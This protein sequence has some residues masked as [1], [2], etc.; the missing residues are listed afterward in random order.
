[1]PLGDVVSRARTREILAATRL[2]HVRYA[3]R[4]VAVLAEEVAREGHEILPLNIGDPLQFDF[5][6]PL[7]LIEAV[8]RAMHEGRSG[9]APSTGV[10]QALEAIRREAHRKG[11]RNVQSVFVT[12]GVS[13]AVDLCLGAL[14]NPGENVLTPCP[15]YPLYWAVLARLGA[16]LNT[17]AL[18]ESSAWEPD[19]DDMARRI[20]PRTRAVVVINPNNPTGT[21][22]SRAV[23]EGI[24]ELARQHN[25]VI[26]AD[27]IYDKLTL[28]GEHVSLAALAPDVP[29]ITFGGLSKAYL[30]PGWRIGWGIASGDGAALQPYLEGIHKLLRSR[31]SANHPEQYAI[32]PAL[33]GPQDHLPATLNKLRMRRDLTVEFAN[34]TP[35]LSC[36]PPQGAFYA[37]PRLEIPDG[38]EEFVRAL[39]REK[40]VLL[41]HGSGFGQ[42]PG[43]RHLRIVFLPDE[44]TLQRA[45]GAIA[46]FLRERYG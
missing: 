15:E 18:D 44:S 8:A 25:L 39:L 24:A 40:H 42:A 5:H 19:L 38:D 27:E 43:T 9:Y 20:T 29:V 17:Y 1:M 28:E 2:E 22:Y 30:A 16:E 35:R 36:V 10:P 26:F 41:V 31:L 14:V 4:D 32:G 11:I 3:I 13:E 7:E 33:D 12:Q 46:E 23:L 45:Y 21:V 37:F 34:S 6:T